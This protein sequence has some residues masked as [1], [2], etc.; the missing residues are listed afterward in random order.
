MPTRRDFLCVLGAGALAGPLA[1]FGQTRVWRVGF[2]AAGSASTRYY[3]GFRQGMRELGY[4]EGTH[5]IIE[6]R[7]ANGKTERL[8]ALAAELV[9]LKVDVILVGG[10][11]AVRAAHHATTTI[12]IVAAIVYD[13]VG[14]GFVAT[15]GRPGGNMTGL[16]ITAADLGPKHLELLKTAVPRLSRVAVLVNSANP[17][18]PP[19]LMRLMAS[20][21]KIGIQVVLAEAS[22]APEIEHEFAMMARERAQAVIVLPDTIFL[23]E[24]QLLAAQAL[25]RRFPSIS[26]LREVTEAGGLLSYGSNLLDNYRRAATYVD[27]ILKGAK[28]GDLPFEQPTRYSLVINAKTAKILGL[29]IPPA[30][31][32]QAEE[33]VQ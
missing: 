19:Q 8:P 1:A 3:N 2:L 5:F 7:F 11:A 4:V 13:P 9:G 18:H 25:K 28:P 22:T 20:A 32:Q 24:S 15:L 26:A 14:D 29:T 33:I 31:L 12:P 27:K 17:S 16:A 30:L 23:G 6:S 21:Q 10:A